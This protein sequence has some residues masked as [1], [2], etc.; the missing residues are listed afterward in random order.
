MEQVKKKRYS[1][2]FCNSSH[3]T[4]VEFKS[5]SKFFNF[6]KNTHFYSKV[7]CSLEKNGFQARPTGGVGGVTFN[8]N[9]VVRKL[10]LHSKY[11]PLFYL[12]DRNHARNTDCLSTFKSRML[13][14]SL[15]RCP[16]AIQMNAMLFTK[17]PFEK[18]VRS[19][20]GRGYQQKRTKTFKEEGG[21]SENVCG[22]L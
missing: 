10:Q 22:I 19:E 15:H 5:V 11:M 7:N 4:K 21:F 18:Y 8:S 9:N 1:Q 13:S 12:K 6:R 20:R 14:A 2:R 17:R 3:Q 16:Q